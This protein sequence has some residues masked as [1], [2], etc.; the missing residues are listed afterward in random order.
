M[1]QNRIEVKQNWWQRQSEADKVLIALGVVG[2]TV[3]ISTLVYV[4]LI[5]KDTSNAL[6]ILKGYKFI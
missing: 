4:N 5:K 3:G 1:E 6:V 2:L